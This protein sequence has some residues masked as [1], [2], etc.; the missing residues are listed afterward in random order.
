MPDEE[1]NFGEIVLVISG[2]KL[3][4]FDQPTGRSA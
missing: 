2:S 3:A 4:L 1:L